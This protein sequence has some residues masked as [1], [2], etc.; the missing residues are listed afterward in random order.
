ML[1][2]VYRVASRSQSLL[3]P[4]RLREFF[5]ATLKARGSQT[6]AAAAAIVA[7]SRAAAVVAHAVAT[8]AAPAHPAPQQRD[9]APSAGV[10]RV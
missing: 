9:G 10:S 1:S 2:T 5:S 8:I 3:T 7:P 6:R 4:A